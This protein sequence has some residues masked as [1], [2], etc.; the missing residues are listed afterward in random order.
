MPLQHPIAMCRHHHHRGE[1]GVALVAVLGVLSLLG[2]LAA[3]ALEVTQR[4]GQLVARSMDAGQARELADSAIRLA[5][6][7]LIDSQQATGSDDH[8]YWTSTRVIDVFEQRVNMTL[9]LEAGRVDLNFADQDLL[10][11]LF[12]ANEINEA[13]AVALAASII[14][15]RDADDTAR[16]SGGER[17]EY[18]RLG[19]TFAPRNAPFETAAELSLVLGAEQIPAAL[20]SSVT[21]HTHIATVEQRVAGPS[22]ERALRWADARQL[23]GHRW[24]ND[25]AGAATDEIVAQALTG[26]AVRVRACLDAPRAACRVAIVRF[27]G[28]AQAPLQVLQWQ[29]S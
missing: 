16:P 15:W 19:R 5:L 7:E 24:V 1:S 29:S 14:D 22:V 12:A 18:Q 28:N 9:D 17:S 10:F 3:G 2:L 8:R 25:E 6:R 11:A 21:V 13:A 27:T 23:G 26:Q 4:H 20:W